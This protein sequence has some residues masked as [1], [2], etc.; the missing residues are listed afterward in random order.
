[1]AQNSMSPS[2]QLI[3][4]GGSAG[5]LD[6]ILKLIPGLLPHLSVTIIIVTHRKPNNDEIL[7]EL[8]SAKTTWPVKEAEEKEPIAPI[9]F[10]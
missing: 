4:I 9:R 7:V 2:I 5:S 8:L 6:V 10:T 1:M 3:V